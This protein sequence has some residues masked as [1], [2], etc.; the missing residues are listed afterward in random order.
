MLEPLQENQKEFPVLEH[1]PVKCLEGH[2][3]DGNTFFSGLQREWTSL[4]GGSQSSGLVIP[5]N[6]LERARNH[7]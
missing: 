7:H 3:Y 1:V 6:L 4:E 2:F 5:T